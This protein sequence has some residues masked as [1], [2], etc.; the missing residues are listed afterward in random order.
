MADRAKPLSDGDISKIISNAL[1]RGAVLP[2][3]HF[4]RRM[5]ERNFNMQDAVAALEER[6]RIKA[7]WN[8][9][10][11]MW[12]Y[13]VRGQDLDGNELTIRIVPRDDNT[14]IVLVTGF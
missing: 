10:A 3:N 4:R 2:S 5:R 14:G 11:D 8:D 1:D 6:R 12:N 9:I 7:V 13:D